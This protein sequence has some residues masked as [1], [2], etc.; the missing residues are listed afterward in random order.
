MILE[1]STLG[2]AIWRRFGKIIEPRWWMDKRRR[3]E[4]FS[5]NWKEPVKFSKM[6]VQLIGKCIAEQFINTEKFV[7]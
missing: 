1:D 3:A 2:K 7:F 4:L 6:Y 5:K